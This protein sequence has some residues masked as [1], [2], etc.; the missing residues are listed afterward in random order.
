[1]VWVL[2]DGPPPVS[3]MIMSKS[4]SEPI[5]EK[6]TESRIVGALLN[7]TIALNDLCPLEIRDFFAPMSQAVAIAIEV[8]G[9]NAEKEIT[10]ARIVTALQAQGFAGNPADV[11][12]ELERY[13]ASAIAPFDLNEAKRE[14]IETA[15]KRRLLKV[16]QHASADLRLDN[17]TAGQV[18]ASLR[19]VQ[20]G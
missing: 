4:C 14:V 15:H 7:G 19:E 8:L 2:F 5:T 9:Q 3:G 10:L 11:L 12:D 17:R 6:N 18:V 20:L 13:M 1:M 16:L